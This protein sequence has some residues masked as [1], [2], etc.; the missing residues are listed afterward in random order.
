MTTELL[1]LFRTDAYG[2][3]LIAGKC[4]SFFFSA[5]SDIPVGEAMTK[6][7]SV[8]EQEASHHNQETPLAEVHHGS[9]L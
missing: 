8:P 2:V 5:H 1:R 6:Q 3:N 4:L 9:L 7:Q